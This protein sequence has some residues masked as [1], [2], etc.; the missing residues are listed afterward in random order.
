VKKDANKSD[1]KKAYFDLAKKYHPDTNK[2][3]SAKDKFVEIQTAWD[4][5]ESPHG[6]S[7]RDFLQMPECYRS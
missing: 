1:I 5:R 2:D 6:P 4:V 7:F 3:A